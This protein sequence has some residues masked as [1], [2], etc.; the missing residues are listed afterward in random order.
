MTVNK[1]HKFLKEWKS[2]NSEMLSRMYPNIKD[3]DI[4]KFLNDMIDKYIEV[5]TA[6]L[7]NNHVHK[8]IQVD[9]LTVVDWYNDNKLIAAGNGTFFKNQDVEINPAATMLDNF[10]TLR[11]SY[12]KQLHNY[13][14]DSYEYASFDR[15]QLIEKLAAN[16]YYGASGNETSN[17]F[18]L[19]TAISTTA[20]GQSLIS[21][22]MTAFESFMADN[23]PFI[24]LEDCMM[25]ITNVLKE[26]YKFNCGFLPNKDHDA[27]LER[28]KNKFFEW[29]DEYEYPL[30]KLLIN[31]SQEE[32]NKLYYKTNLYEFTKIPMIRNLYHE[33]FLKT[34]EFKDPTKLPESSAKEIKELWAYYKEF[35]FYNGFAYNRIQRLKNDIRKCVV[36]IDTDSNMLDFS[37][38]IRFTEKYV[39][40]I[41]PYIQARDYTTNVFIAVNTFCYFITEMIADNLAKYCKT[42]NILPRFAP[43]INMKNEFLFSRMILSDTKKRYMSKVLLRE[44]HDDNKIDIK[45]LDFMKSSTNDTTKNYLKSLAQREILEVDDINIAN[46]I[47]GTQMLQEMIEGDLRSGGKQ[48]LTPISVKEPEAYDEPLRNQGIRGV[49]AWNAIYP[50][51]EITLPEKLDIIKVNLETE[52]DLEELKNTHPDIAKNII[53]GI[54]RN[55]DENIRKKGIGILAIPRNVDT[56]PEWVIPYINYDAVVNGNITKF[57]PILKSLGIEIIS[58]ESKA[59]KSYFS[60]I[61]DF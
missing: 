40:S 31:L 39:I 51:Q 34:E 26:K 1:K 48:F 42:S 16:S 47:K 22:T 10:L 7:D 9:L 4:N 15:K 25:F 44:G 56:I 30:F 17:F 58:T 20:T 45:G 52:D 37:E 54:F 46:V 29:K 50:N 61:I 53:N 27:V 57:H 35:V 41:D 12:K 59:G 13:P 19:Y 11:K 14:N 8:S 43:R 28:F 36:T 23:V 3:K 38:L 33:I 24:D 55:P 21:T 60:N 6:I 49:I 5:P 2:A 18:N 32:L